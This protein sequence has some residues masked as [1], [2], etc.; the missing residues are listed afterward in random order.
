MF[1]RES[2]SQKNGDQEDIHYVTGSKTA[3]QEQ[4]IHG[5]GALTRNR[6]DNEESNATDNINSNIT[7]RN[8]NEK[9]K[10]GDKP[11]ETFSFLDQLGFFGMK[12]F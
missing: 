9:L 5:R 12:N 3:V 8:E 10:S 11:T 4:S 6:T 1:V 7:K 2:L